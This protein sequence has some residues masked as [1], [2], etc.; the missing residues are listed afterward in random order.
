MKNIQVV[1][2]ANI[3]NYKPSSIKE[4]IKIIKKEQKKLDKIF[5]ENLISLIKIEYLLYYLIKIIIT[6]Y[7][8]RIMI[9]N[10][11][12]EKLKSRERK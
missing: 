8:K 3:N 9:Q 12:V 2:K 10:I 7:Y 1:F 5:T 6:R 4:L 11:P